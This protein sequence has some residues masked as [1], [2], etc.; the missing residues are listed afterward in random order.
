MLYRWLATHGP[1]NSTRVQTYLVGGLFGL[2]TC[3][4]AAVIASPIFVLWWL[5][6]R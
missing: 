4:I 2:M 3:A 5:A 1:E 6:S